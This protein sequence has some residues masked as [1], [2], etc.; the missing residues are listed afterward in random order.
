MASRSEGRV[1]FGAGLVQGIA[2]VTFPAASSILTSPQE[3]ALSSTSYGALFLPQ[4]I[5]AIVASLLGARLTTRLGLKQV[6][7]VG[8]AANLAAMSLLAL[9]QLAIGAGSLAYAMLL[10][11]TTSLGI[12]FGLTVPALN[13]Y[14]AAF[15]PNGPD[16]AVLTLNALLGLGTA[17]APVFVA[18]FVG[19]GFWWGLPVLVAAL[20]LG[21]IGASVRL[22]LAIDADHVGRTAAG[23]AR[24]AWRS[25]HDSGSSRHSPCCM[26]SWRPSTATGRRST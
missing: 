15:H 18:L 12:G 3:Y 24:N 13:R 5:M 20:L 10:L 21:L 19:L 6:F 1:V 9:S 2:L 4:A 14:A 25:L 11:A 23:T 7:V 22:P 16:R 17:L 8:L 26:G